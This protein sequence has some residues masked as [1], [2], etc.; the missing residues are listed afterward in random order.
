M[1]RGD[2]ERS[3]SALGR[4]CLPQVWP[5][6]PADLA[7]LGRWRSPVLAPRRS[8]KG[9][10]TTATCRPVVRQTLP[11]SL[12]TSTDNNLWFRPDPCASPEWKVTFIQPCS[13]N[14]TRLLWASYLPG[15]PVLR[16]GGTALTTQS[17]RSSGISP[18]PGISLHPH[19]LPPALLGTLG[20]EWGDDLPPIHGKWQSGLEP[21]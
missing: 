12:L 2:P 10:P 14:P 13:I 1:N 7:G 17:F 3:P 5:D 9:S 19:L 18:T 15:G 21:G 20:S 6:E 11:C 4:T 16:I 8:V